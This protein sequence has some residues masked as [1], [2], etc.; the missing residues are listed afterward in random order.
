[1]RWICASSSSE[2]SAL[3][4]R[5][6]ACLHPVELL[7]HLADVAEVL[8]EDGAVGRPECAP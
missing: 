1:M 2:I 8:V 4:D 5:V 3:G 7:F 6:E